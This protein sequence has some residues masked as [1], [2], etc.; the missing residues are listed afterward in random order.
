[1]NNIENAKSILSLENLYFNDIVFTRNK[2]EEHSNSEKQPQFG[3]GKSILESNDRSFTISLKIKVETNDY[4]LRMALVGVFEVDGG[5]NTNSYFEKNA[6][7]IM[8]PYLR[9]QLTL[10]TAQPGIKPVMLP[11]IN[12][13]EL[14]KQNE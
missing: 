11:P 4:S 6:I 10:I 1:M 9:S 7:A 2:K 12:I 14:L 5:L 8:F 13:N 3:F